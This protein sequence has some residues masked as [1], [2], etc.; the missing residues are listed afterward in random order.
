[1]SKTSDYYD[2][3]QRYV[4]AVFAERLRQAG[5]SSYKGEDIHWYRLIDGQVVQAVYFVSSHTAL[6]AFSDIY[7]GCHPLYIPPVMKK[8]PYMYG[9]PGYEQMNDR[10]PERIPGS[11]FLGFTGTALYGMT[12]RPYREDALIM[13]PR[14]KNDGLDILEEALLFMD[15][16]R[17]PLDCYRMHK[18]RRAEE[19][20]NDA[21]LTMSTYFVDEVLY[22]EDEA[23]YPYCKEYVYNWTGVFERM[24]RENSLRLTEHKALL[25]RLRLLRD[26]FEHGSRQEYIATFPERERQTLQLLKKY[27]NLE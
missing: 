14:D 12:N 6:P 2:H 11:T 4:R 1:M 17:T 10:I 21:A 8:S 26:V 16:V 24:E 23:L 25:K 5:F 27:A 9:M 13:C 20:E 19:I 7:F 18:Q 3:M 15:D 22:W